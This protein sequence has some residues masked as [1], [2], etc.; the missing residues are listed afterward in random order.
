[1][2]NYKLVHVQILDNYVYIYLLYELNA[3]KSDQEHWYIYIS[4]S[5]QMPNDKYAYHIVHI[6]LTAL[7]L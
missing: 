3:T 4:H 6:Y 5:Q 2:L 1:M 7:L